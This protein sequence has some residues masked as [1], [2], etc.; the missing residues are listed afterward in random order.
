MCSEPQTLGRCHTLVQVN[1]RLWQA[2][3]HPILP[4]SS[5]AKTVE[6]LRDACEAG[7]RFAGS[8]VCRQW[9]KRLA[10]NNRLTRSAF[11]SC[12]RLIWRRRIPNQCLSKAFSAVSS[13]RLRAR[14][15]TA[16]A[17]IDAGAGRSKALTILC[18]SLPIQA[19]IVCAI[20][21]TPELDMAAI[22]AGQTGPQ[23][24]QTRVNR[25]I[26]PRMNARSQHCPAL[27]PP[28]NCRAPSQAV[29][30]G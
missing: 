2:W 7:C 17:G 30:R 5:T 20:E 25:C 15:S 13:A 18:T 16:V 29:R 23:S 11:I 26:C 4:W 24:C 10:M 12:G 1:S 27:T 14:S 6:S 22:L 19:V 21:V 3:T 9:T 8:V 28:A